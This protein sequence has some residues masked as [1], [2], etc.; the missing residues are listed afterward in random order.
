M[1][2]EKTFQKAEVKKVIETKPEQ[3][4]HFVIP[5]TKPVFTI[6]EDVIPELASKP[7]CQVVGVRV[8]DDDCKENVESE[9]AKLSHD[10]EKHEPLT[11]FSGKYN[12]LA[13]SKYK[14]VLMV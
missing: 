12:I 6:F 2:H 13:I 5:T 11:T 9:Y 14:F 4:K 10:V 1:V 8:E 3:P 7:P